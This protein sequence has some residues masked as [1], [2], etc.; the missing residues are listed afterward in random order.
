MAEFF[1]LMTG[2]VEVRP[3]HA[4]LRRRAYKDVVRV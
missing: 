4:V 3:G 2:L 1:Y